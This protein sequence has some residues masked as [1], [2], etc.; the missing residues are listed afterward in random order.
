MA[1]PDD[2]FA[3][4]Q[5]ELLKRI[6]RYKHA[7][8]LAALEHRMGRY[9]GSDDAV[10]AVVTSLVKSGRLRVTDKL[11]HLPSVWDDFFA[12]LG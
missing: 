12:D 2:A 5:K 9:C 1:E 4:A 10:D 7:P 8:G 6:A 11:F 3:D